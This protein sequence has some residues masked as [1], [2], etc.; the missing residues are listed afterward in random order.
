MSVEALHQPPV[1]TDDQARETK[2]KHLMPSERFADALRQ[3]DPYRALI[4]T[5][6]L[7]LSDDE[8]KQ[9]V[10]EYLPV[11]IKSDLAKAASIFSKFRNN[12]GTAL[13]ELAGEQRAVMA[14]TFMSLI[15]SGDFAAVSNFFSEG[16]SILYRW[17][18]PAKNSGIH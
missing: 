15:R 7:K 3:E 5:A 9:V 12:C 6:D 4:M 2:E 13:E 8:I 11:I 14:E 18:G 10:M 1:E 17:S 16:S